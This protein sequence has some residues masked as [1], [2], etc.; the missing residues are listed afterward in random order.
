[1]ENVD[2]A[3]YRRYV[4]DGAAWTLARMEECTAGVVV[5]LGRI[6]ASEF[7]R[8]LRDADTKRSPEARY[9][10]LTRAGHAYLGAHPSIGEWVRAVR[11]NREFAVVSACH[12]AGLRWGR[13]PGYAT[14][15]RAVRAAMDAL[16]A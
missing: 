10:L 5:V 4:L 15:R 16:H 6:A 13:D 12:P 1:V 8:L 3:V 9:T 14:S 11:G 7:C 2:R